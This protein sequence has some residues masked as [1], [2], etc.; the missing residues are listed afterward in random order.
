MLTLYPETDMKKYLV[1]TALMI[2]L[3]STSNAQA[4][5]GG[6][7]VVNSP[8]YVVVNPGV[9]PYAPPV[10]AQP[11][12]VYVAP[13]PPVVY[14]APQPVYVAPA[15]VYAAPAPVYVEPNYGGV[16]AAGALI[17]GAAAL[18]ATSNRWNGGYRPYYRH[19]R[20]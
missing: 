7:Y 13:P 20:H 11:A 18:I 6:A 9:N 14:S 1:T 10:F 16:I 8:G 5:V 19:Y 2:G 4:W 15:P 17:G 12:P 3:I